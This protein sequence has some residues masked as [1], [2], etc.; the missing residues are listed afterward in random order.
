MWQQALPVRTLTLLLSWC[1]TLCCSR[2]ELAL[3]KGDEELAREALSR[4]KSYQVGCTRN[5]RAAGLFT[6]APRCC[7]SHR[8][9][10]GK[11]SVW[12][13]PCER[14]GYLAPCT[15]LVVQS[16]VGVATQH[17]PTL[18]GVA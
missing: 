16:A 1:L 14:T 13:S 4:R 6:S 15:G 9:M 2:A 7:S 8:R 17:P 3:N 5:Q 18:H 12:P 11:C 10:A